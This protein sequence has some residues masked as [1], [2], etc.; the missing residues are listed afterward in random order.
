[1]LQN[2]VYLSLGSNI[3]DKKH[4]LHLAIDLI[5]QWVATVVDVSSIYQSKSWGFDGLDF[6][7]CVIKVHTLLTPIQIFNKLQKIEIQMG[8]NTQKNE[9]YQ[10]RI[11]DVDILFFNNE[12]ID[13]NQLNIP[14][15]CLQDR[16]F[17]LL[18]MQELDENFKHPI[19][20]TSIENLVKTCID[21][22][23]CEIVDTINHQL[24]FNKQYNY[25]AIE[26][27]IGI[28]K[29]TLATKISEDFN[30][31]LVLERF[32]DNPFLPKFYE[33]A[34]RYAFPLEVSF[35]ADRY[36]QM[37]DDLAQYDLFKD[38]VIADYQ[39]FKSIIFAQITLS[40]DEL[41]L[42][43][44]LFDIIYKETPK[45]DLYIYLYQN[46][47]NLLKNIQKRGRDYEQNIDAIYLEKI[48][49]GYLDFIK[50]QNYLNIHIIDVSEKDY[51]N[52][53]EDYH[54]V[55]SKIN[56]IIKK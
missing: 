2:I 44:T 41:K 19:F 28:G 21:T 3:G 48:N 39:I 40:E 56:S 53:Q 34:S 42:Y 6:Y 22:V 27:N 38:F 9:T 33:D 25:I 8:R 20:N 13:N 24:K 5:H 54:W 43:K 11:I 16:N 55:I 47:E 37:T 45:P 52:K 30:A 29:T 50:N 10:N 1:M 12:I 32:A 35:L 46:I 7:N 23:K 26:G 31:K 15:K 14:H 18:P 49:K 4:N 36:K 17:V 51:V